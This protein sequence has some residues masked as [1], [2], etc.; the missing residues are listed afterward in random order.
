ML[1]EEETIETTSVWE[2][3]IPLGLLAAGVALLVI[4]GLA[5]AGPKGAAVVFLSVG[6]VLLIYLPITIGAMFIA[7]PLVDLTFGELGPAV[8]KMAG[9]YVLTVAILDVA[10]TISHPILGWLA[11]LVVS[12][13]LFARAFELTLF[14]AIKAVLVIGLVRGLLELAIGSMLPHT[15][16]PQAPAVPPARKSAARAADYSTHFPYVRIADSTAARRFSGTRQKKTSGGTL[17]IEAGDCTN[18]PVGGC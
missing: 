10:T 8:A 13:A 17:V 12:L 3:K 14:D 2:W 15:D 7:A 6:L 5:T 18:R 16:R 4:H 9:I 11:A 1:T